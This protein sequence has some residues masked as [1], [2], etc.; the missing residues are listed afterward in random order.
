MKEVIRVTT[1]ICTKLIIG[2]LI[3]RKV[4]K[5]PSNEPIPIIEEAG[6]VKTNRRKKSFIHP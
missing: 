2:E 1:A 5:Y 6:P 3:P 4:Y